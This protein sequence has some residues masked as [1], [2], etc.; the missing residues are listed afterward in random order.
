M[1]EIYNRACKGG[2]FFRGKTLEEIKNVI[3]RRLNAK[4][5][6]IIYGDDAVKYG[7]ADGVYGKGKYK[8]I[9]EIKDRM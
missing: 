7:F 3:K 8:S 2:S 1:Y 6:W 9:E 5:D 4:E